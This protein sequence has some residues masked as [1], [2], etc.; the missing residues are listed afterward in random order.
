MKGNLSSKKTKFQFYHIYVYVIKSHN[1]PV[2]GE[3]LKFSAVCSDNHQSSVSTTF[4]YRKMIRF[5]VSDVVI[6]EII[7]MICIL[8][9][10]V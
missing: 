7:L 10:L 5:Y 6:S 1:A 4:I 9:I 3:Y 8:H 2:P